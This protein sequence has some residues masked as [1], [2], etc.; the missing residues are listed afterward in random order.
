MEDGG[1]EPLKTGTIPLGGTRPAMVPG[2]GLPWDAAVPMLFV[3][4]EVQ[5]AVTG[6]QGAAYAALL[7]AVIGLP[8]RVWVSYD[9]Y[10]VR[11]VFVYLRTMAPAL[12]A[13]AWGGSTVSHFPLHPKARAREVRGMWAGV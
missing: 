2:I 13:R 5:M 4:A 7:L 11:N 10:A 9:W 3:A 12:D 1:E 8:L 6:V